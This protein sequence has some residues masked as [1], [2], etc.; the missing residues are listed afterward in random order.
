MSSALFAGSAD[1]VRGQIERFYDRVGGFGHLLL[2]GQAGF[3]A[4][5]E[6]VRGI[7]TFAGDVKP[8]LA[9]LSTATAGASR[10]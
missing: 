5:E 6:T 7:E 3:L 10:G 8:K 9:G 1:T 4:H 2:M